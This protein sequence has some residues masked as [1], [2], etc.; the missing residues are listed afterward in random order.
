MEVEEPR[1]ENL[2]AEVFPSK[3][4]AQDVAKPV[5]SFFGEDA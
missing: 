5:G 2:G 4:K 3:D 1:T